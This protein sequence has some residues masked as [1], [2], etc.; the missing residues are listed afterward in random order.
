MTVEKIFE[1]KFSFVKQVDVTKKNHKLYQ[2]KAYRCE[3]KDRPIAGYSKKALAKFTSRRGNKTFTLWMAPVLEKTLGRRFL[4]PLLISGNVGF[5]DVNIRLTK[6]N[7]NGRSLK[8]ASL[9]KK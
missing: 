6:A 1:L 2:G 7:I 5:A 4:I 3:V 8:G 9:A